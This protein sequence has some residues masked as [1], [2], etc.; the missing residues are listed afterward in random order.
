MLSI[1]WKYTTCFYAYWVGQ[2]SAFQGFSISG[3]Q[4][5][6][7]MNFV[8]QAFCFPSEVMGD[9]IP[10]GAALRSYFSLFAW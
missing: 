8:S 1:S 4:G 10:S 2:P 5:P 9:V 7:G 3:L 6:Q